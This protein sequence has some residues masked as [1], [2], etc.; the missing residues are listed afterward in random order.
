[1]LNRIFYK[2]TQLFFKIIFIIYNRMSVK[3][4][5]PL[6]ESDRYIVAANHCSNLDPIVAGISFPRQLRYLAKDEL[7]RPFLFGRIIRVLGAIPVLQE[8]RNAAASALKSFLHL[9]KCGESVI[10]FPEG[11]RSPDG[12]LKPLEGGA[13]LISI[14]SGVPIIPAY[15]SGTFEAMPTGAAWVKPSKIRITFGKAIY[16][17][18]DAKEQT[19]KEAREELTQVLTKALSD[20]ES[21]YGK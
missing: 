1:M 14:K 8:D 6:P 15:I 4:E 5:A 21:K 7:F 16:P 19:S 20:M 12:K 2:L 3:W 9:L 10:L 18:G 17:P 13:A 11:T